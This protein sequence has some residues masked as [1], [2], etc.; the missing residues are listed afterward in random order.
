M[1]INRF[2][3]VLGVVLAIS[4]WGCG[5]GSDKQSQQNSEV[6][7][8]ETA[9]SEEHGEE[10]G[11]SEKFI[12]LNEDVVKEFGI[13]TAIANAGMLSIEITVPGEIVLNGD[14]SAHIAPRFPGIVME[15][16]KNVGDDVTTGEVLAIIQS[17]EGLTPYELKSLMSGTVIE[18]HIAVGEAHAGDVE[19][20]LVADLDT[21]W[22]KLSVFQKDIPRVRV[23]QRVSIK[24]EQGGSVANNIISYLSPVVDEH[25]RTAT[26]RVILPNLKGE[27]RPGLFIEGRIT[28][29][30]ELV[31]VLVPKT[32]L[33]SV[34]NNTVVFVQ[35]AD[36]FEAR[37]VQIGRANTTMVEIVSGLSPGERFV[38]KGSFTLKAEM[39]K[40]EFGEGHND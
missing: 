26:L 1:Q 6:A 3:L 20:F 10:R 4:I 13:E 28:V 19:A 12:K 21:V 14:R 29:D 22:A 25:T 18:K 31:K 38:S 36:G 17:N 30:E 8:D 37:A 11:S 24:A 27:W 9:V 16:R 5:D 7:H 2:I 23:G 35:T 32:A 15:V 34:E 39:S 33:Q 40:G